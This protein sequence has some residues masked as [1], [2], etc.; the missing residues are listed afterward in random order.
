MI[1]LAMVKDQNKMKVETWHV[2]EVMWFASMHYFIV[3]LQFKSY[4]NVI[5][6]INLNNGECLCIVYLFISIFDQTS[7]EIQLKPRTFSD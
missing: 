4:S 1:V 6:Q 2:E 3:T 7:G 5:L